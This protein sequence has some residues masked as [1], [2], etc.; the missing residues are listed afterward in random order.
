MTRVY[1]QRIHCALERIPWAAQRPICKELQQVVREVLLCSGE[2][3]QLRNEEAQAESIIR[4][5]HMR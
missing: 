4:E 5:V 1:T 3:L 2:V